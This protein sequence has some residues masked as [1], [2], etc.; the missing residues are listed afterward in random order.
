MS[1]KTAQARRRAVLT[2][3]QVKQMRADHKPYVVGYETLARKYG[4]SV[5]TA[6]DVC[7][8]RTRV[9]V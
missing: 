4:C 5:S 8:Y 6:R 7:T 3:A 1:Y 2:D 9:G